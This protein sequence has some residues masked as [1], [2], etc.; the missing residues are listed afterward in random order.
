MSSEPSLSSDSD[1][2]SNGVTSPPSKREALLRAALDLFSERTY[3]STPV[4]DIAARA[5]VGTGTVYRHFQSKEELAN[6]VYR[7]CKTTMHDG[8]R[9]ALSRGGSIEERFLRMWEALA[10]MAEADPK[11]MR[12]IELQHHEE[13]LDDA[14]RAMSDAVF[15][16]AEQFMLDGQKEG[17]IR[18][19]NPR[20]LIALVFG[21]FVGLFKEA[22]LGRYELDDAKI[23]DAGVFAWR[24][25]AA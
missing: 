10:K 1:L 2:S 18:D 19:A 20:M 12:F 17:A 15:G 25:V 16:T 13:Y 11:A 14:S 8:L 6:T 9:D 7:S 23:R 5:R 21:A 24:I 22:C 3:G 4:P